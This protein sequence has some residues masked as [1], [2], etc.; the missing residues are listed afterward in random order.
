LGWRISPCHRVFGGAWHDPD[1]RPVARGR[2]RL[3]RRC[4]AAPVGPAAEAR[5]LRPLA[6]TDLGWA[7]LKADEDA[8]P[9]ASRTVYRR[10]R[11]REW[12]G[13]AAFAGL[14]AA[15]RIAWT[16]V[17]ID[18]DTYQGLFY[19]SPLAYLLLLERLGEA[20]F[21]SLRGKPVADFGHGGMLPPKRYHREPKNLRGGRR[22]SRHT[23]FGSTYGRRDKRRAERS[24][25]RVSL[26]VSTFRIVILNSTSAI[27]ISR[28]QSSD[29][30]T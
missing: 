2:R 12:L 3:R 22:T 29:C 4:H 17:T 6:R 10:G 28:F 27:G 9:Y 14:T 11:A 7:F 18:E 20:G 19:G 1:H 5:K 24:R 15:D 16:P 23:G 8:P 25:V 30:R 13:T 26:A 21:G